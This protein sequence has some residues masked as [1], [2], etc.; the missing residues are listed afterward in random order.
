VIM[1][2]MGHGAGGGPDR[3]Q[4]QEAHEHQAAQHGETI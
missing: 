3:S 4:H 2:P 1:G